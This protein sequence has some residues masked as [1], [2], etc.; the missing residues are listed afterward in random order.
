MLSVSE[1]SCHCERPLGRAAIN[2]AQN[3]N[4][5]DCHEAKASRND[6]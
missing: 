5:F 2:T 6:R 4:T 1:T 3:R